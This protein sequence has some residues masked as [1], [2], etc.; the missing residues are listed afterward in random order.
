[1]WLFP[2]KGQQVRPPELCEKQSSWASPQQQK[3]VDPW[4]VEEDQIC[5]PV[6]LLNNCCQGAAEKGL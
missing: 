2:E 4:Q 1:M 6:H 5:F 3:G